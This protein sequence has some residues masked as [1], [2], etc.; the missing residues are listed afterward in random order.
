MRVCFN[1]KSR[2][3][4]EEIT[5]TIMDYDKN[6]EFRGIV[7]FRHIQPYIEIPSEKITENEANALLSDLYYK[8]FTS[9]RGY[10]D[11]VTA[12]NARSWRDRY[13]PNTYN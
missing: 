11:P 10:F 13:E 1:Y 6:G 3:V 9:I 12:G 4:I 8:G 5:G 2:P 7:L